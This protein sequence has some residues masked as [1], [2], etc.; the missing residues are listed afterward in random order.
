MEV[1]EIV[2]LSRGRMWLAEAT[3]SAKVLRY[4]HVGCSQAGKARAEG[5][6]GQDGGDGLSEVLGKGVS[7]GSQASGCIEGAMGNFRDNEVVPRLR[8]AIFLLTTGQ[9]L[10]TGRGCAMAS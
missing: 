9:L 10:G 6:K 5:L 1:R 3:A 7:S 2:W 4:E 8:I